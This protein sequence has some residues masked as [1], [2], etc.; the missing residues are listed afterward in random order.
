MSESAFLN[1]HPVYSSL[2]RAGVPP[3]GSLVK[4]RETFELIVL[5][6]NRLVYASGPLSTNG[7]RGEFHIG[8][9]GACKPRAY[10]LYTRFSKTVPYRAMLR[11]NTTITYRV[12]SNGKLFVSVRVTNAVYRSFALKTRKIV[13]PLVSRVR[14]PKTRLAAPVRLSP[15]VTQTPVR[16]VV[17]T[18]LTG[19]IP[20]QSSYLRPLTT[21]TWTGTR[22][23]HFGALK[24]SQR[25][26]NS[27]SV[28]L[29][30]VDQ[31]GPLLRYNSTPSMSTWSYIIDSYTESAEV[32]GPPL[33]SLAA[34]NKAIKKLIERAGVAIEANIAQD[35]AQIGQTVRLVTG[36]AAKL[37]GS[38]NAL[39]KGN[40]TKATNILF[41]GRN[42]KFRG[43]GPT[44]GRALAENW[45]ELQY[46]W[47]PLLQ[48]IVGVFDAL[49]TLNLGSSF[50]RQV[51]GSG[52]VVTDS[53]IPFTQGN[54]L[55][56]AKQNSVGLIKTDSS[57]KYGIRFSIPDPLKSFLAQTGFT[58]PVNLLWEILP[59]SFVADWFLPIGPY[60]E[61]LSSWDGLAF[62]DG[63]RTRFTRRDVAF[64]IS[65][66][67]QAAVNPIVRQYGNGAYHREDIIYDRVKLFAFPKMN[68]PSFKNGLASVPHAL[69]GLALLQ[70]AFRK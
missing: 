64:V 51:T 9:E 20:I 47:K 8:R 16:R 56:G 58:N 52:R 69:N 61:T 27:H 10:F 57:C 34:E 48:D 63:Y 55:P 11:A 41:A 17:E 22:T 18:W 36:T 21:R 12:R 1:K 40:L 32:P 2:L 44:I 24:P 13:R 62:M 19:G 33:H 4:E 15:E 38:V 14:L 29:T 66:D 50:V 42:P 43:K 3:A 26:V 5:L 68:L 45:L 53:R 28:T 31:D 70:S 65:Y 35:F 39:R 25:P 67:G 54:L 6:C 46:G 7:F 37:V 60:L 59:F 49:P 23:P 30:T